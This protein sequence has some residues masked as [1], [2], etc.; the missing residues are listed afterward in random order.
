M[1]LLLIKKDKIDTIKLPSNIF[2]SYWIVDR[3]NSKRNNNLINVFEENG[4]WKIVSN[5]ET[6][7]LESSGMV[8]ESAILTE[9]SFYYIQTKEKTIYILYS[10]PVYDKSTIQLSFANVS[11]I[12]IGSENTNEIV[13]NLQVIGKQ[14]TKLL[15]KDNI[16]KIIDLDSKFG[17]YLNGISIRETILNNGDVIFIMGLKITLLGNTLLI[18]NPFNAVSYNQNIF[19][20]AKPITMEYVEIN[21]E[22]E[23]VELYKEE[24]YFLR[25]PRFKTMIEKE[26]L[27]IDPP[28]SKENTEE[29]PLMFVVGPML[30]MSMMSL[31]T[32]FTSLN[33]FLSGE[34]EFKTVLPSLIVAFAMMLSMILWPLLNKKYQKKKKQEYERERQKKYGGY[35]DSRREQLEAISRKQKQILIENYLP[36]P[37]CENIIINRNRQLWER[38]IDQPDFLATRLGIGNTP[39]EVDIRYPETHF[40]MDEDNLKDELNRMVNVSKDLKDVPISISFLEKNYSAIVGK[41][42]LTNEFMKEILLQF[43]TFHSFED[44]KLVFLMDKEYE[45]DWEFLKPIPHIWSDDKTIR[46]FATGYE[47][48]KELSSVLE[49]ELQERTSSEGSSSK[50]YKS[51]Y[52][53]YIII[54]NNYTISKNIKILNDVLKQKVNYGYSVIVINETLSSLPNECTTFISIDSSKGG[55]FESE[56]ISTKQKEFFLD[57]P[58][59]ANM[60]DSVYTLA[61]TPLKLTKE[62]YSLP[63]VYSFLEMFEVGKVE[64]LNALYRWKTNNSIMS[65]QTPIGIDS[66]GMISRLDVHEKAHG[67]HGL[68]AGMTGS[69][70][71]ELIITYIVSLAV[72]YHPDDVSFVLID[73]KGGFLVGAL[74]NNET[75]IKL[76]HLAGSITNL[77]TVEMN[78]SLLSIQSE[79]KRRQRLFN[80][81]REEL[82]ESTMDIYK[83]QKLYHEGLI[84]EPIP[85]LLI[86]SDEFAELKTQQAEFMDQLIS[87]ARIGRSLGVHLI[88]ATQKP[89]GVVNDQ[90][91]SNS[92][93]KICLKVQEKSD[94]M[95]V[96]KSPDAASLTHVGRYYLQVGYNEYFSLGQSAWTGAQYIPSDKIKKEVDT[97]I[98]F[99]N[100]IG[101]II[102]EV[103]EQKKNQKASEGDQLTSVVKYLSNLAKKENIKIKQLWLDRIPEKIFVDKLT[104]KYDYKTSTGIINPIIGEFDDPFNQSQGLLTLP[105]STE[106]NVIIYGAADSGKEL[107]LN[108]LIYSTIISHTVNEVNFYI[109]DFGTESLRI[110]SEAPH[111]GDVLFSDDVEKINNIF[112]MIR[113]EINSRKKIFADYYGDYQYFIK[114]SGKMLPTIVIIINNFEAF[115][116]TY[117][118]FEEEI[119]QLTREGLKY[120]IVFVLTVTTSNAIRYKLA[121]NFRQKLSLQL[122]DDNDYSNIFD[123]VKDKLPSKVY[124]R[125]LIELSALHEFQTAFVKDVENVNEYIINE[126][127]EL[128]NKSKIVADKVMVLPERVTL[129]MI[130]QDFKG[131]TSVPI[132][133]EK[134]NLEISSYNFGSSIATIM[135]SQDFAASSK[136]INSFIAQLC[137]QD[138]AD[139]VVVDNDELLE[140]NDIQGMK[141][142][143]SDA[144][145]FFEDFKTIINEQY[146]LYKTNNYSKKI[147]DTYK[148]KIVVIIGLEKFKT[149]LKD[150]NQKGLEEFFTKSQEMMKQ[151]YIFVENVDKLKK[152]EYDNWYRSI[153]NSNQGIWL[154]NGIADQFAIKLVKVG[155]ELYQ[156]IGSGFGYNVIRGVPTLVKL[157]EDEDG[158][159]EVL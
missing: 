84:K 129:K 7:I 11:E 87:T 74:Q 105:L 93:F 41:R 155:K 109:M 56:L 91:W 135:S 57:K 123:R 16:W 100:N 127:K 3:I 20:I 82:N 80:E 48:M 66:H 28:P 10:C 157:V 132:G 156:D 50:D 59:L 140:T 108:S 81:V 6:K 25:S 125:G 14:N 138:V 141:Y 128:K 101:E 159:G 92:R 126:C 72:N 78:R 21:E 148:N 137:K 88:L 136:F 85:H 17:T 143:K 120:G 96:I 54:T 27:V 122:N 38:K 29:L 69:G 15:Y 86:I 112:K 145:Q 104:Q 150:E 83:Y 55:V 2:G 134:E 111:V 151:V 89:S 153:I 61:N 152:L 147:L 97:S 139:L 40:A 110:F 98:D 107:L 44:L 31:M 131:I 47:E 102:K 68:I 118:N 142:Y 133:I 52:P 4:K 5:E 106:G 124:G 18:N 53:Y 49:Q 26:V 103:E 99:I 45:D 117:V 24:D 158:Y 37:T 63:K 19:T 115:Q 75:G 114:N 30:S 113:K 64:Q 1:Q 121:K 144:N 119:L 32:V 95:D 42:N 51:F 8:V 60:K 46:Y 34:A 36:A 9:Y 79:L 65:L 130:S 58:S 149:R 116:E 94:S 43:V 13:Y 90:I 77:D 62:M 70:K 39:L 23:L 12:N 71:S 22:D 67:P 35:I 33:R 154:G 146:E 76:P 73:Y